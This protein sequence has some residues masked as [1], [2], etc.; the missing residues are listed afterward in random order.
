MSII[1]YPEVREAYRTARNATEPRIS[2][3]HLAELVGVT[4]RHMIRIENGDHRPTPALRDRIALELAVDP[5]TLPAVED[6]QPF[7]SEAA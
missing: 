4:R 7:R 3:E 6:V 5:S 1:K 2:Q